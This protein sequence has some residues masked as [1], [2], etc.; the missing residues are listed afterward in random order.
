MNDT[1]QHRQTLVV[2][3]FEFFFF[4]QKTGNQMFCSPGGSEKGKKNRPREVKK[5]QC[6]FLPAGSG[7]YQVTGDV[8]TLDAYLTPQ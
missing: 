3:R 5:G 1:S 6:W 7:E 8:R 4:Q 2:I